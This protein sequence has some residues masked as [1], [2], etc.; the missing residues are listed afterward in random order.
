MEKYVDN[1]KHLGIIIMK[2][3]VLA[4]KYEFTK[5]HQVKLST[6]GEVVYTDSRRVHSLEELNKIC[7]NANIL[8]VDPDNLGGFDNTPVVLPQLLDRL[9]TVQGIA[10]STTYFG[11]IDQSYCD[12]KG[13]RVTNV[14]HYSSQSVAEYSISL[15]LG[16]AKR[17]FLSSR[18]AE[19]GTYKRELGYEI[20]GKTLGII[21]L[22]DIGKKTAALGKALGMQVIAW[23]RTPKKVRGVLV[24][25]LETVLSQSDFLS[26]HLDDN[27]ATLGFLSE[28]RIAQLKRGVIVINTTANRHMVDEVAMAKALKSGNVDSYAFEAENP[29]LLPLSKIETAFPLNG[30]TAWYTQ[31]ALERNKAI[32]VKNIVG[33]AQGKPLN[34]VY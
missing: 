20:A 31:E 5:L 29:T 15:L 22:G 33:L 30:Y 8:A 13:V 14:P 26:L 17:I 3:T 28:S 4:P 6:L 27:P 32:W 10:L 16:C 2:I 24:T 11:F 1:S 7:R 12:Q 23:N 9:P 21:G 19:R 18:R 25:T 34:R